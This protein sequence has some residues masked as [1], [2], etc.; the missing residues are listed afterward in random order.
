MAFINNNIEIY[1]LFAHATLQKTK[2]MQNYT[3]SWTVLKE[4][5]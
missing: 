3:K 4:T 2:P 1:Y 5:R